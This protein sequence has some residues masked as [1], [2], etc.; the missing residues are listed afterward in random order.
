MDNFFPGGNNLIVKGVVVAGLAWHSLHV[1]HSRP[2]EPAEQDCVVYGNEART[3][4]VTQTTT[5]H[6]INGPAV[7]MAGR[8]E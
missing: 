6:P 4:I 8:N 3:P 2:P 5:S 1:D 7:T